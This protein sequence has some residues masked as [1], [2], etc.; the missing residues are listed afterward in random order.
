MVRTLTYAALAGAALSTTAPALAQPAKC[1]TTDD[2][3]YPCTFTT[4]DT[5]GSF[6]ISAQGKPSFRMSMNGDGTASGFIAAGGG[7]FTS[8]PGSYQRSSK[9]K[10]C[11]DNSTTNTQ[12]CAW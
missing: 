12:I 11:W 9:D 3:T 1:L 10:A 7:K 5:D 4:T 6:E 2:G 8:L